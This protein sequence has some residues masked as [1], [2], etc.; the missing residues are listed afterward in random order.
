MPMMPSHPPFP[1]PPSFPIWIFHASIPNSLVITVH[2]VE[3]VEVVPFLLLV[4]SIIEVQYIF[5]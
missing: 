3:L 1:L 4:H 5:L 2:H